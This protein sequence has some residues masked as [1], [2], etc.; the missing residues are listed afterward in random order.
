MLTHGRLIATVFLALI[1]GCTVGRP[2]PA[3]KAPFSIGMIDK[4]YFQVVRR[5]TPLAEELSK[6]LGQP[7]QIKSDRDIQQL[8]THLTE[9]AD[10]CGLIYVD[11]VEFCRINEEH[12]LSAVAVRTNSAGSTSEVG[13]IVVPKNSSI[14]TLDDLKGKRFAFGPYESPHMFYNVLELFK[15]GQMPTAML[16]NATYSRDSVAVAQRLVLKWS[17]AGVVTQTWWQTSTDR[18]GD[19]RRLLKDELRIIAQTEPL[20]LSVWAATASVSPARR[21]QLSKILTEGASG[22]QRVLSAF[23]SQGFAPVQESDMAVVCERI[24]KVKNLPP[25]PSLLPLP[26]NQ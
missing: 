12:P 13:L 17:D 25:P 3:G 14:K 4:D 24:M 15:A 11:P 1:S 5:F 9:Q 21:Q 8:D 22:N 16:K 19:I 18:A 20:P 10:Y 26:G 6:G 2:G 23:D 7:V